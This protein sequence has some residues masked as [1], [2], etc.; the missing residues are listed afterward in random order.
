MPSQALATL[1]FNDLVRKVGGTPDNA[2]PVVFPAGNHQFKSPGQYAQDP[3]SSKQV[4]CDE[5]DAMYE[6]VS[7]HENLS[8]GYNDVAVCMTRVLRRCDGGVARSVKASPFKLPSERVVDT[9]FDSKGKMRHETIPGDWMTIPGLD[10]KCRAVALPDGTGRVEFQFRRFCQDAINGF[11]AFIREEL[12]ERSIYRGQIITSDYE[13]INVANFDR[14]Q[15]VFNAELAEAIKVACISPI[16]DLDELIRA[17][18]RPKR[19]VLL[20]GPP[21][22]GKTLL[23]N[24]AQS[25]LF[26]M[27]MTGIIVKAGGSA[28][29]MANGLRV[30]RNYMT[31]TGI[32]GLFIEDIEK[33]A[34]KDRS[35]ALDNLDG[36]VA[37]SDRILIMM[38]T[39]FP[40]QINSAFLRQGRVDD[41]IEVGLP[42]QDAFTRLIQMRLKERLADDVDWAA[43][44]EA[45]HD[46]T[47]AW[48][49]GGMSK[50]IR[51][52]IAR[53]HSSDN[54]KVGTDDLVTGATLMRRQWELQDL[55]AKRPTPLPALDEAFREAIKT[56]MGEGISLSVD[57]LDKGD[58]YEMAASAID[59]KLDGAPLGL[60]TETG[61]PLTGNL[62]TND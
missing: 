44:F 20:S 27:G 62:S 58:V 35:Q 3:L 33:M 43:A 48:I 49:V 32:V 46:Y 41:Y 12:E 31:K 18:E 14:N 4:Y 39:N 10:G 30:A 25:L 15:V 16:V 61:K 60:K 37:K 17:G 23:F 21:G 40:D 1:S 38:T 5:V 42:D 54:I 56:A 45:F 52:V 51:S 29:D 22:T 57:T 50:V 6:Y 28:Q 24:V 8:Y 7:Q 2:R 26:E 59:A 47:P 11:F 13:Y 19:S 53:T 36:S 34:D 9:G 55:T